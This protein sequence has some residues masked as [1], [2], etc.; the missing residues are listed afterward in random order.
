MSDITTHSYPGLTLPVPPDFLANETAMWLFTIWAAGAA[1]L[2]LPWTIVRQ[3]KHRDSMPLLCWI[4]GLIASLN[5]GTI[6]F[7][8]HLWWP[9]NLP[10]PA[11]EI[12]GLAVPWFMVFAYC[13]FLGMAGYWAYLRIERGI[14][15]KGVFIVWLLLGLS[16]VLLEYPGVIFDVYEYYGEHPFEFWGYPWWQAWTNATGYLLLGLMLWVFVPLLNGWSKL[17]IA[18]LPVLAFHGAWGAVAWPN[19]IALNFHGVSEIPVFWR[20]VLSA[21][22][23]VLCLITVRGMAIFIA[24]DCSLSEKIKAR[25]YPVK[26][27]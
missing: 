20:W 22:S 26:A 15:V 16:D 17:A 27:L 14:T 8:L 11:Y 23:L 25:L 21:L 19:Y 9:T 18:L 24:T 13:F 7:N 1:I 3:V 4:G 6:D 5:E 2:I 10:G 12:F